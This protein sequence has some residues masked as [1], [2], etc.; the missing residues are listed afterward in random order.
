[1]DSHSQKTSRVSATSDVI[2]AVNDNI[3]PT[4]CLYGLVGS[5]MMKTAGSHYVPIYMT[6]HKANT[7]LG[8]KVQGC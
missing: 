6:Y 2:T 7:V 4:C 8:L 1:M 5:L 3:M